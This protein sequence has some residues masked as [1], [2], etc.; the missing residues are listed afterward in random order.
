MTPGLSWPVPLMIAAAL[1]AWSPSSSVA[2]RRSREVTGRRAPWAPGLL[3]TTRAALVGD[4]PPPPGHAARGVT[5]TREA[6]GARPGAVRRR[7][8]AGVTGLGIGLLLGGGALGLAVACGSAALADRLLR[9]AVLDR[10]PDRARAM[11]EDLPAVCDLLAVCLA[12]G[13]PIV[14]ALAAVSGTVTEPLAAEL[15]T[16]AALYRLGAPGAR[17]WA[18]VAPGLAALG[19]LVARAEESGASVVA[20]LRA[21]AADE[22]SAA[23]AGTD[24]AVRRAGVWVLAPLG[25]CFLPAFVC[26]GVVPLVLGIAGLV[27]R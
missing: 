9:R 10:S 19:R 6:S 11:R 21:M 15:R 2:V 3:R 27:L 8:I 1:L 12:A 26:L 4:P 20:A 24:A 7:V 16:V 5:A 13:V 14:G 22:R 25:A 17:A 23:R 18:E